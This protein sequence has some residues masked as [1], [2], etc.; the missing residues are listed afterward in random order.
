MSDDD[1]QNQMNALEAELREQSRLLSM[2]GEREAALLAE[3]DALKH[4]VS[5]HMTALAELE[6]ENER[7]QR[8]V[9]SAYCEGVESG[10]SEGRSDGRMEEWGEIPVDVTTLAENEWQTSTARS[11]LAEEWKKQ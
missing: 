7:L 5:R 10:Y 1:R 4:D 11:A 3:L 9:F 6:A 8:L 2:N